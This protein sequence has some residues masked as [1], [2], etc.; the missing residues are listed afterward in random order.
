MRLL[1][2]LSFLF[3]YSAVAETQFCAEETDIVFRSEAIPHSE[4]NLEQALAHMDSEAFDPNCKNKTYERTP[5]FFLM[6]SPMKV[7]E[8]LKIMEKLIHKGWDFRKTPEQYI[9]GLFPVYHV[10]G[11]EVSVRKQE[12]MVTMLQALESA[13]L[14]LSSVRLRNLH[15]GERFNLSMWAVISGCNLVIKYLVEERKISLQAEKANALHLAAMWDRRE[16]IK[17]LIDLGFDKAVRDING[18]TAFD[19]Y[20]YKKDEIASLLRN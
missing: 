9:D 3:T 14:D 20:P 13:G 17:F 6:V 15:Y 5:A 12:S 7:A 4:I 10:Y 8:K 19:L 2:L 1:L 16:T 18:K 11:N